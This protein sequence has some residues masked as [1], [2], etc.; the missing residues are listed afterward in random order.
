MSVPSSVAV[1]VQPEE[2]FSNAEA[3][4]LS[5]FLAGY[6]GL[7]RDAYALDLRQFTSWCGELH[8]RLLETRRMHIEAFARAVASRRP[9]DEPTDPHRR[10]HPDPASPE[11]RACL[12][13]PQT[14]RRQDTKGRVAGVEAT[15][16]RHHLRPPHRRRRASSRLTTTGPG[17][18]PG[19]D[20]TCQRDR[21]QS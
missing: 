18:H 1:V 5:G 6:S 16:Q 7:T 11:R 20:S 4:A 2:V 10:G 17:G 3:L 13:R 14:R 19:N 21:P 8:L 12:L 9:H 15:H